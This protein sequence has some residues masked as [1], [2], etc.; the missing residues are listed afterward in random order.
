MYSRN[1][2]GENVLSTLWPQRRLVD[3]NAFPIVA[4]NFFR[5]RPDPRV[6]RSRPVTRVYHAVVYVNCSCTEINVSRPRKHRK[7][8]QL[9]ARW[10]TG[11]STLFGDACR[12]ETGR[13]G[14]VEYG[15]HSFARNVVVAH[16][17]SARRDQRARRYLDRYTRNGARLFAVPQ[18][19]R[20]IINVTRLLA[21]RNRVAS[22][23]RGTAAG[24]WEEGPWKVARGHKRTATYV[25]T[26]VYYIYIG[27][28]GIHTHTT[29]RASRTIGHGLT[30]STERIL[31]FN[32]LYFRS[33]KHTLYYAAHAVY[34]PQTTRPFFI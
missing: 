18:L 27:R 28:L 7:R 14:C 32:F 1:F 29:L 4:G 12:P 10:G 16:P 3:E 11:S 8:V 9:P 21:R 30:R 24:G 2:F 13:P 34:F 6:P 19:S 33:E 25:H 20:R 5:F 15:T 23:R 22:S 26:D 17:S 31:R